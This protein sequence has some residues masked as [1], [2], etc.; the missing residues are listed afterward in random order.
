MIY[1][2]GI[3]SFLTWYNNGKDW[4]KLNTETKNYVLK[5]WQKY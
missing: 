4:N 3:G 5:Y 1:N 2:M